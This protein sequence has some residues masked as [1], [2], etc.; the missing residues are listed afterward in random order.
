MVLAAMLNS[1]CFT[2]ASA[3]EGVGPAVIE[4]VDSEK[5]RPDPHPVNRGDG[6]STDE[7]VTVCHDLATQPYHPGW[8]WPVHEQLDHRDG[9]GDDGTVELLGQ[10]PGDLVGDPS[11]IDGDGVGLADEGCGAFTD[12]RLVRGVA[13]QP[14]AWAAQG[15][16]GQA[17]AAVHHAGLSRLFELLQ[18]PP[19]RHVRDVELA[20]EVGDR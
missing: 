16:Q 7:G 3:S 11:G 13:A 5:Q 20:G 6:A 9:V 12:A 17:G 19:D 18:V 8:P 14:A 4:R 10:S 15:R 1:A 2:D